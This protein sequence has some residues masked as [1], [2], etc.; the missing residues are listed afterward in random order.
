MEFGQRLR[1]LR[2]NKRLSQ[3]DLASK[4][5]IDF[6]YLSKI[7]NGK[8]HPPSTE[9]IM[10]LAKAL[11]LNAKEADDLMARAKKVPQSLQRPLHSGAALQFLRTAGTKSLSEK[12]WR[13]L[14][15]II[16]RKKE[17]K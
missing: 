16:D 10:S 12:D 6:T 2:K 14:I 7:E 1:E 3:R 15:R 13:D 8:M 5:G 9:T 11:G 4:V 17:R